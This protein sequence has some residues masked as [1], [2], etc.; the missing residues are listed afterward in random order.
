MV[1]V[2]RASRDPAALAP[3]LRRIVGELDPEI[4]LGSVRTM[5]EVFVA[6]MALPRFIMTLLV[7]FASVGLVLAAVGVY[8]VLAQLARARTREMGI[9]VALGARASQVRWLVVRHALGLVLLGVTIGA[10]ASLG[11][12][13]ALRGVLYDVPPSDPLTFAVVS[14]LLAG[15][16]VLAA[17]VPAVRASRAD[18]TAALREE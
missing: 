3:L 15:V 7:L 16:A 2:A 9:R 17:W 12:T 5:S 14:A 4:A 1:L 11:A 8:G 18:P 6:S 13:R 10:I